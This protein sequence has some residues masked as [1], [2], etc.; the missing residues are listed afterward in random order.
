MIEENLVAWL[1]LSHVVAGLEIPDAAPGGLPVFFQV[2]DS[3]AL[4]LGFHEPIADLRHYLQY[5]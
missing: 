5:I 2:V 1:H 4:G 3:V